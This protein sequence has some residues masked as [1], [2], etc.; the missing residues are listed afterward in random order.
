MGGQLLSYSQTLPRECF[1]SASR[2][3]TCATS[4][5]SF[6]LTAAGQFWVLTRFPFRACDRDSHFRY[7]LSTIEPH[8][9][10]RVELYSPRTRQYKR[11]MKKIGWVILGL[12]VVVG[13]WFVS[14]AN[15]LVGMDE[16]TKA[17]W[18]QVENV[19]QRR[20]DLIPNL[21]STV[22]GYAK[23]EAS[24]LEAVTQARASAG[25]V[26]VN[27]A[28]GL[29]KFEQSQ[30]ALSGALSRLMVIVEKYPD[31]KADRG[32]LD[33]QSQLEGTENRIAVERKR[34]N[35]VAQSYNTAIR[36][37]P[38]SIVAGMRGFVEKPY[39]QADAG[40][41]TVPKVEF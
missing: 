41:K 11:G 17:A 38:A 35:E 28:E 20:A 18:S 9:R 7:K 29:R 26:K 6:P 40:A 32:F 16:A 37:F 12:L 14:T 34:F 2:H 21:V 25:Q 27:D 15:S 10:F 5:L 31:L 24:V 39:F 19:Y 22:K 36:R 23:H 3:L 8:S 4:S 30:A 1:S 13:L 33:L